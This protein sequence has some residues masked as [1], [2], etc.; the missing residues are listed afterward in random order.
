MFSSIIH[1]LIK[2][3]DEKILEMAQMYKDT[4]R[5]QPIDTLLYL[6]DSF[7]SGI[8][9]IPYIGEDYD[10]FVKDWVASDETIETL[11]TIS[12][13]I[14]TRLN[15]DDFRSF[16]MMPS[17]DEI[18]YDKDEQ[19]KELL[20]N[21]ERFVITENI[22]SASCLIIFDN[23]DS[24]DK[25][26]DSMDCISSG[27]Y[28]NINDNYMYCRFKVSI[29][30][31]KYNIYKKL[32]DEFKGKVN[33]LILR[34]DCVCMNEFIPLMIDDKVNEMLDKYDQEIKKTLDRDIRKCMVDDLV[35]A[36]RLRK[37]MKQPTAELD[38]LIAIQ[39]K[40]IH[41]YKPLQRDPK[42]NDF[43]RLTYDVNIPRN[44]FLD[45]MHDSFIEGTDY[46]QKG[47]IQLRFNEIVYPIMPVSEQMYLFSD[48][49]IP[50]VRYEIYDVLPSTTNFD[51]L[52]YKMRTFVD[53]APYLLNGITITV[54][55]ERPERY[56]GH[57][58][59]SVPRSDV[60]LYDN[61]NRVNGYHLR[62]YGKKFCDY[63]NVRHTTIPDMRK[64]VYFIPNTKL[65]QIVKSVNKIKSRSYKAPK[66]NN[67]EFLHIFHVK[68]Q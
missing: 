2:F 12:K 40:H 30:M 55:R 32:W 17:T 44:E 60:I 45:Y 20:K 49:D 34:A 25:F 19:L 68:K 29:F 66:R 56:Y 13:D 62:V 26:V 48:I 18:L 57:T 6:Y 37:Q 59:Y 11:K 3:P 42:T 15:Y 36:K 53:Y 14:K 54:D 47:Y 23:F 50:H 8:K 9:R 43:K 4:N 61:A 65:Y 67:K 39:L 64:D 51:F 5:F 41:D 63:F 24:F 28:M 33:H 10:E 38:K 22:S 1:N 27:K 52:Y 46:F 31:K 35:K 58:Y 21:H 16:L 7:K